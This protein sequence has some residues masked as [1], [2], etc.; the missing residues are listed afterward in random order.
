MSSKDIALRV[1][2]KMFDDLNRIAKT[3]DRSRSRVIREMIEK[4]IKERKNHGS[5]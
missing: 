4:G 1:P 5:K 2:V 3:E